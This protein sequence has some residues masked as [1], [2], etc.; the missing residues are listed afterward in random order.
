MS[1]D[2]DHPSSENVAHLTSLLSRRPEYGIAIP[3]RRWLSR[4]E[5]KIRNI[6][7][8]LL[9]N[10]SLLKR[11]FIKIAD[12][13]DPELIDPRA[14]LCKTHSALNPWLIRCFFLAVAYEVTVHTDLLRSWKGRMDYPILSSFAGRVDSIAAL[15]TEPDLYSECYGTPPFEGHLIFVQ[16]GCEAC[17][18]SAMGANARVL[19]DL[20]T[21]LID[22]AER[23]PPRPNGRRAR[24][25]KLKRYVDDWISQLTEERA[26]KCIAMSD[27]VLSELRNVR[28][29]LKEWRAQ[30]RK[31]RSK[32]KTV[33][34]E[35]KKT[36]DGGT[37]LKYVA[38]N[39]RYKRRTK[40]GIPVAVA[41]LEGAEDQRRAAL[42]SLKDN[43]K[44]VYRPDSMS[45]YSQFGGSGGH[46]DV[47][48]ASDALPLLN[49]ENDLSDD[50]E[51]A[52]DFDDLDELEDHPDLDRDLEAE[53]RSRQ[54]VA[55][56]YSSQVLKL[57][58][59]QDDTKSVLSMAHPAFRPPNEFSHL[60]AAP[61]PLNIRRDRPRKAPPAGATDSVWTDVTV[62]TTDNRAINTQ[63][64]V[65][66]IPRVPSKYR[67]DSASRNS[68]NIER[69]S[70][71]GRPAT[72]SLHPHSALNVRQSASS[73]VYSTDRSRRDEGN[74]YT[75]ISH[76]RYNGNGSAGNRDTQGYT[77][78]L[79]SRSRFF[80]STALDWP[81]S[82][83]ESH[84]RN[85]RRSHGPSYHG[86]QSQEHGGGSSSRYRSRSRPSRARSTTTAATTTASR[87]ESSRTLVASPS[88]Q[89][90][91]QEKERKKE[92]RAW[93]DSWGIRPEDEDDGLG[94][95]DSHSVAFW[96]QAR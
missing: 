34:T 77:A 21:T 16:S 67:R 73:S 19:A 6:P 38:D 3:S 12:R 13:I 68:N 70:P 24:A 48:N 52:E 15:W 95:E 56:W 18:L 74:T 4:Q 59:T 23:R 62:Y 27:S 41:D 44:S 47:A 8:E 96:R 53:E 80:A 87:T 78:V 20:R 58:L 43:V 57:D 7:E 10:S 88:E 1:I 63:S 69:P 50:Y 37:E 81:S 51:D 54:K 39:R 85:R 22:R 29:Q 25:P 93:K 17:I 92:D 36:K 55:N 49:D 75:R 94:P 35:L 11:L 14:V 91:E 89:D 66:P 60:S 5:E 90:R 79:P 72:A 84:E 76:S 31:K 2:L 65:P 71:S 33:Y 28:P 32:T 42:F 45:P 46:H 61:S 26:T 83:P 30:R 40:N 82:E 86:S 9:N 64:D